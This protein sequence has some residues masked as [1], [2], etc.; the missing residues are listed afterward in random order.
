MVSYD[1]H[2]SPAKQAWLTILEEETDPKKWNDLLVVCEG[3]QP[4]SKGRLLG[5]DPSSF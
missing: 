5:S 2:G 4:C 3:Q 1:S